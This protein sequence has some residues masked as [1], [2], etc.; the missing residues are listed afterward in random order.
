VNAYLCRPIFVS[1]IYNICRNIIALR[2]DNKSLHYTIF[3]FFT[4]PHKMSGRQI[5]NNDFRFMSHSP[6][7]IEVPFEKIKMH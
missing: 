7:S 5:S 4:C 1:N 6:Q 2:H 3:F